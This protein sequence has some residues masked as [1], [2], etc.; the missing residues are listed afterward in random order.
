MLELLFLLLPV[1]AAS[2]W[3]GARHR[4]ARI[5]PPRGVAN[6]YFQGLNYLLNEQPDKAIEVFTRMVELD[7]ETVEAQLALGNLFRRRGEVDRAIRLHQ[8]IF[9]RSDLN[10][11]QRIQA[12]LELGQDYMRAGLLD[13][14]ESLF[15]E[16]LDVDAH[17]IPALRCLVDIYQQEKDWQQA[18]A[19]LSRLGNLTGP[20]VHQSLAHYYC[21]LAECVVGDARLIWQHLD[22]ALAIDSHCVRA[23]LLIAQQY[24]HEQNY[25]AAIVTLQQ[26]EQQDPNLLPEI[27]E[28]LAHCFRAL[29]N[30]QGLTD[31]LWALI[32]RCHNTSLII[33]GA[34]IARQQGGD[35][36]AMEFLTNKLRQHPS[37]R[38]TKRLLELNL[39][40]CH[41]ETQRRLGVINDLTERLLAEKPAYQC[42]HCG[43]TGKSL[44]WQCPGCKSWGTVKPIQGVEG[45]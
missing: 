19:T 25:S 23:S 15:L 40:Y 1:A 16:L 43:F 39:A 6:G 30:P 21:E 36:A 18:I 7:E 38:G 13:R 10:P 17:S 3:L 41:G 31:Y 45:D 27:M 32:N 11:D 9:A 33:I 34:E 26:V 20:P 12:L 4:Y 5:K 44:H 35:E 29:G 2:G 8:N 14:A 37:V 24:I 42:S 28:P 22:Q